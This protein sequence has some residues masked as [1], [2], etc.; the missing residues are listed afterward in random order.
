[1]REYSPLFNLSDMMVNLLTEISEELGRVG[2]LF[3]GKMNDKIYKENLSRRIYA[4]LAIE[5][6]KVS[7]EE[8]RSIIFEENRD[9]SDLRIVKNLYNLY[10]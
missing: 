1:M 9:Y 7:L 6:S 5:D 4:S 2:I 3:S 10:L 8:V